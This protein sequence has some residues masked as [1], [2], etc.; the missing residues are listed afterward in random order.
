MNAS[1]P[2]RQSL[3]SIVLI[4]AILALGGLAL[5]PLK[6]ATKALAYPF[7]LD[8]VEG[9]LFDEAVELSH[10]R[11]IYTPIDE[12]PYLVGNYPPLYQSL[13]AAM[14]KFSS[15]QLAYGRAI[16]L[17]ALAGI[18]CSLL[19]MGARTGG[20]ALAGLLC[21]LIFLATYE[22][23]NWAAYARVDLPALFLSL[24][25]LTAFLIEKRPAARRLSIFFFVLAAMTKQTALSAPAAC[26][27]YLLYRDWRAGLRYAVVFG[28]W[29]AGLTLALSALTRG[30]YF[31]HTVVYNANEM[32]WPKLA[33]WAGHLWLFYR[34]LILGAAAASL[35]ALYWAFAPVGRRDILWI[36]RGAARAIP[37]DSPAAP[38]MPGPA[39][40]QDLGLPLWSAPLRLSAPLLSAPQPVR[41]RAEEAQGFAAKDFSAGERLALAGLYFL[42]AASTL[43]T[44]AKA[45]SAENYL[46]EPLAACALFFCSALGG[47][48]WRSANT[49]RPGASR[50]FAAAMLAAIGMHCHYLIYG[51]LS[52]F[53]PPT[54]PM[55]AMFSRGADLNLDEGVNLLRAIRSSNGEALC[56]DP[57]F[58]VLDGR[59]PPINPFILSQLAREGRWDQTPFLHDIEMRRFAIVATTKDF[60]FEGD[61]DRYTPEMIE[62]LRAN[63]RFFQSY[64][65]GRD[66][67]IYY[68]YRPREDSIS[69][70]DIVETI[71]AA[72][73]RDERNV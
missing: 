18:V 54:R 19:M 10:G 73:R 35:F 45:G 52:R 50:L 6:R 13:W 28:G 53:H 51:T 66:G 60:R 21:P 65:L 17:S 49:R 29:I 68:L 71:R 11:S 34:W 46:L 14:I 33:I 72:A 32:E 1:L 39:R 8:N 4:A 47:A 3:L 56:E 36:R 24:A 5:F 57:V 48:L 26:I 61:F 64:R 62:A 9:Y 70:R 20:Q 41:D 15:P 58:L 12:P 40:R 38:A 30:Q 27:V 67:Q 69:T 55:D 37:A 23:N 59:R 16:C 25:G 31:L 22:C 42:F 43:A 63:Y 44:L 2:L 7:Q